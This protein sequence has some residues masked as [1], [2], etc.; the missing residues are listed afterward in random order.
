M[1]PHPHVLRRRI[2][3]PTLRQTFSIPESHGAGDYVLRLSDSVERGRMRATVDA[4]VVT[5]AIA[6]AF[7][8]AIGT[9][10]EALR[11][12]ENKAAYLNGSF[13][14]GKSHFMAVLYGVLGHAP[15][16]LAIPELQPTIAKHPRIS[17]ANL[18]RLTFHFLDSDSIES[19]LFEQYLHQLHR[20]HPEAKPPVLHSAGG[21]FADAANRRAEVGTPRPTRKPP[22]RT[23]RP[24][25]GHGSSRR[26]SRPTSPATPATPTGSPSK[27]AWP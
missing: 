10:E 13:G 15:E 17:E 11:T 18:L 25:P 8:Q 16:A 21:L 5:P 26:S 6:K 14:S 22:P 2:V 12:H 7:D 23:P 24:K 4:Y 3:R 20:L 1:R 27:R 9:V 19:A